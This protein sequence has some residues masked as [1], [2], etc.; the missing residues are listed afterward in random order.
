MINIE[1]GMI[2]SVDYAFAIGTLKDISSEVELDNMI[3][4]SSETEGNII[5]AFFSGDDNTDAVENL[6]A[7]E[8]R[9]N[10][11]RNTRLIARQRFEKTNMFAVWEDELASSVGYYEKQKQTVKPHR[12]SLNAGPTYK[13]A[14]DIRADEKFKYE[15]GEFAKGEY[16]NN[17][18]DDAEMEYF[19][20]IGNSEYVFIGSF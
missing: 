8:K 15:L 11:R 12:I 18:E 17:E 4:T 9:Y 14:S 19:N 1:L 5:S 13:V 6:A 16:D 2:A 20:P 3:T 10:R 7:K